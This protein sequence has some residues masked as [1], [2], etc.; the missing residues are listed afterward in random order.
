MMQIF[1]EIREFVNYSSKEKY[2]N[3]V[4]LTK[5]YLYRYKNTYV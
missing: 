5:Q 3:Y 1:V 4:K 2:D